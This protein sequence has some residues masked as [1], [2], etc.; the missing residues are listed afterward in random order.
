M[1]R[2]FIKRMNNQN[3]I[4]AKNN[5]MIKLFIIT[6]VCAVLSIFILAACDSMLPSTPEKIDIETT[7]AKSITSQ[8]PAVIATETT[9]E[10]PYVD[11][12]NAVIGVEFTGY[13]P[14]FLCA[15]KD[16]YIKIDITNT[17]EFSWRHTRPGIV[18]VGYHYYGQDVDYVDYDRTSRTELPYTLEPGETVTLMVL[19][20]DIINPG[21][22]V[23]QLDPVIEGNPVPEDNFWFSSKGVAMLQGN[24]YF[25]LCK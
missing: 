8:E 6:A 19:I 12:K 3:K 2:D 9:E 15:D 23:I 25:G 7:D 5:I 17:S 20:N 4:M 22:Y 13:I 18:R 10:I 16:N 24:C 14:S 11:Y 1:L 21:N